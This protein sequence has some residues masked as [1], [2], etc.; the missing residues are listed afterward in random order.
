MANREPRPESD[1]LPTAPALCPAIDVLDLAATDA[2]RP[3]AVMPPALCRTGEGG[4]TEPHTSSGNLSAETT[5]SLRGFRSFDASDPRPL[6]AGNPHSRGPVAGCPRQAEPDVLADNAADLNA[7]RATLLSMMAAKERDAQEELHGQIKA[8]TKDIDAQFAK[9]LNGLLSDGLKASIHS[10][11]QLALC[12]QPGAG[13]ESDPP[14]GKGERRGQGTRRRA[15]RGD[16]SQG[17]DNARG[18]VGK[19]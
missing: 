1:L 10:H 15:F 6:P 14:E 18:S 7:V 9:L 3:D 11:Q 16:G 17:A 12:G 2:L 5:E 8:L 19:F 13:W 4:C